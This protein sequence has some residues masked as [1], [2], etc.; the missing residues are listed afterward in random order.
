MALPI[1]LIK[2]VVPVEIPI[3][4]TGF[5]SIIM[6]ITPTAPKERPALTIAKSIDTKE[7]SEMHKC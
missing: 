2:L 1:I 3:D 5:A 6:F 7:L 4:S